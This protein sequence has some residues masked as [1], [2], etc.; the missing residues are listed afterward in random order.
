MRDVDDVRLAL[1][2]VTV[3]DGTAADALRHTGAV[4]LEQHLPPTRI[5]ELLGSLP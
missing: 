5:L 2:R 4:V 1:A 3:T